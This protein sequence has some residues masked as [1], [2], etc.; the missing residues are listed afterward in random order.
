[1]ISANGFALSGINPSVSEYN[2]NPIINS[3]DT[4][5]VHSGLIDITIGNMYFR[6]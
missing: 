5:K 3:F 2:A 1:M 4:V 6:G